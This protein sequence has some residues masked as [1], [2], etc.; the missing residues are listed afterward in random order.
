MI[1]TCP[2]CGTQYVVKDGAIPPQG[3]QVRCASC[4]H[5]WHQDPEP[6]SGADDS[7]VEEHEA[8]EPEGET[9]AEATLIEPRSGPEAEERA[10]EEAMVEENGPAPAVVP[11][12]DEPEED[13]ATESLADDRV[14]FRPEQ[15][16]A[17]EA[18]WREPP[19]PEA[20]DD[21]FS[22]F[23]N[24]PEN[25]PR[26]GSGIIR[27][28]LVV[29]VVAALA[30]AFWFF[31]PPEWKARVGLGVG[32]ASP[33]ALV[34]THMD[35]QRL[36]SGNELLTVTGRVI[37]PTSES[38]SVPP[39]QAQLKTKTGQVVYSWTIA[40]PAR[41]LP[42]GASAR[43]NSAEVNVPP[44]GDELTISLGSPKA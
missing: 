41:S 4:K 14:E 25:P 42:P 13:R 23:P 44:G 19:D 33:L 26:R 34:T 35:R 7:P 37:N 24:R 39:L 17:A 20:Q 29:L 6:G 31:A 22:P 28:V 27:A 12:E 30:A 5:S 3:R 18:D 40:P 43:F 11:A 2:N 21:S 9:I 1:L 38:Q 16:P 15:P 8:A 32:G 10:Y 36:E